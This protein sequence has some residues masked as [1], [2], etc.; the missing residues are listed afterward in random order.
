MTHIAKI[1]VIISCVLLGFALLLITGGLLWSFR[2]ERRSENQQFQ[3]GKLPSAAL[4]GFYKGNTQAK[5]NWRGK[6]FDD[7]TKTGINIFGNSERYT[8][9]FY[10]AK[11]LHGGKQVLKIDYNQAGNPWWLKLIVDE[12]VEIA[13]GNH[14]G[15]VYVRIGPLSF[16]LTYFELQAAPN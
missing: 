13:P 16:T 15:K 12:L 5:T 6:K 3:A 2:A 14:Q 9:A 7:A 10:P 4:D 1:S 11:S 8:F